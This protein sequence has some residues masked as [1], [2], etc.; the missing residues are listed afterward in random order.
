VLKQLLNLPKVLAT[1]LTDFLYK[2]PDG[3][4]TISYLTVAGPPRTVKVNSYWSN[5]GCIW[6][7]DPD[8]HNKKTYVN[9]KVPLEVVVE[10]QD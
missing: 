3:C 1:A 9:R 6:F 7:L 10:S 8:N 4:Y 2:S 5:A